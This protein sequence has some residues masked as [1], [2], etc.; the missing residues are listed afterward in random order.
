MLDAL[1]RA[2]GRT[3]LLTIAAAAGPEYLA[4]V[5]IDAVQSLVDFINLMT[6]QLP[7]TEVMGL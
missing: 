1:G 4:H 5:E 6:C 7:T 2:H 3:Y